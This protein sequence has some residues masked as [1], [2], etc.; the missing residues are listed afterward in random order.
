MTITSLCKKLKLA[1][2][3]GWLMFTALYVI[4]CP[5]IIIALIRSAGAVTGL[6]LGPDG[7]NIAVILSQ[8]SGAR[9]RIPLLIPLCAAAAA[10]I[11][12]ALITKRGTAFVFIVI[13]LLLAFTAAFLFA[14]VNGVQIYIAIGII[15]KLFGSGIF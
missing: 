8:L 12:R 3:P 4:S 9:V 11:L 2:K 14:R 5:I 7:S 6:L 15:R 13:I 10:F 1:V